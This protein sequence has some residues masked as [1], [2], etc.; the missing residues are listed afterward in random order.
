LLRSDVRTSGAGISL[1]LMQ[2]LQRVGGMPTGMGYESYTQCQLRAPAAKG[3]PV[4]GTAGL[5]YETYAQRQLRLLEGMPPKP[6]PVAQAAPPPSKAPGSVV[7]EPHWRRR[8][9]ADVLKPL[10][11]VEVIAVEVQVAWETYAQK[12]LC[13]HVEKPLAAPATAAHTTMASHTPA[14]SAMQGLAKRLQATDPKRATLALGGLASFWLAGLLSRQQHAVPSAAVPAGGV[15]AKADLT[16]EEAANETKWVLGRVAR[17]QV[18]PLWSGPCRCA[19][20][21][22]PGL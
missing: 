1:D 21:G 6:K 2:Y 7:V 9:R 12:Q 15:P 4:V 19:I 16:A 18:C 10:A 20:A 11:E 8:L 13:L 17:L 14:G 22:E 3:A 5:V